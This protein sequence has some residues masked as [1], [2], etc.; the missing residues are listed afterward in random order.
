MATL[1]FISETQEAKQRGERINAYHLGLAE[2][3]IE[4][5]IGSMLSKNP[6]IFFETYKKCGFLPENTLR[7]V[8][9]DWD[10]RGQATQP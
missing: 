5:G 10:K 9:P 6:D 1:K 3:L 8:D 2:S 7:I 4:I